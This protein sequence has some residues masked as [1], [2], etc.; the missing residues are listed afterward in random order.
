MAEYNTFI[1]DLRP[2]G[3]GTPVEFAVDPDA[4][5]P[6]ESGNF[7]AY[8]S[9]A[10]KVTKLVRSGPGK[11]VGITRGSAAG[12]LGLGNQPALKLRSISIYTTGV[13]GVLGT[14][15]EVYAHGDAV[16]MS[17]TDSTKVTKTGGSG[18]LQIGTVHLP[19]GVTVT[20]AVRVPVLIDEATKTQ[21]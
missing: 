12:V 2:W 13:H 20:G 19:A 3:N 21:V 18:I 8:D 5:V 1:K 7:V 15:A 11:F 4:A 6:M 14:T 17:G 9:T 16:Y 10:K